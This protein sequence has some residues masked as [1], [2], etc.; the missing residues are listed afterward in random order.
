[1]KLILTTFTAVD[2]FRQGTHSGLNFA[3]GAGIVR[4]DNVVTHV[5]ANTVVLT[6]DDTNYIEVTKA[7]VVSANTVGY[8][9]G[10]I[11]LYTVVTS[12]GTITS[13]QDDRC[14]MF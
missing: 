5:A 12:G 9:S 14:F 2:P 13:V 6:D 8:T 10:S 7:G 4:D 3:Y 11:P 1:L